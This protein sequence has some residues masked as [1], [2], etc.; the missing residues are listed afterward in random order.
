M[1]GKPYTKWDFMKK[2]MPGNKAGN[3]A[4]DKAAAA[5]TANRAADARM[6]AKKD[7]LI[8]AAQKVSK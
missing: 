1:P 7:A 3:K 5:K 6:A 4:S 8:R 2:P